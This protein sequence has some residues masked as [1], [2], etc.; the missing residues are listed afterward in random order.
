MKTFLTLPA[1]VVALSILSVGCTKKRDPKLADG[2]GRY[3]DSVA[4][5]DGKVFPLETLNPKTDAS[6]KDIQ[7]GQKLEQKKNAQSYGLQDMPMVDFRTEAKLPAGTR[8]TRKTQSPVKYGASF[9]STYAT[10]SL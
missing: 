9:P 7:L 4:N 2:A 6:G 10:Q 1:L 8:I 3:S 5:Y